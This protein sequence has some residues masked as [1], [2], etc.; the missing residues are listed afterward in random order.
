MTNAVR[1]L[2]LGDPTLAG[3]ATS[4]SRS[5]V[6]SLLWAAGIIVVFASLAVARFRRS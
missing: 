4:T 5:V 6:L 3:V 2:M 1:S